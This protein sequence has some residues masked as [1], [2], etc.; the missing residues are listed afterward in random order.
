MKKVMVFV[1]ILMFIALFSQAAGSE[2]KENS[3]YNILESLRDTIE[4]L[5]EN[6]QAEKTSSPVDPSAPLTFPETTINPWS[7][8]TTI[9]PLY[10]TLEL[11]IKGEDVLAARMRLFELG[12]YSK[13]PTQMDFT[14]NMKDYVIEFQKA[15]ALK[16][17]GILTSEVQELLFSDN[18]KPKP[19]PVQKLQKPGNVKASVSDTTVTLTWS[20]VKGAESYNVYR[21]TSAKGTYDKIANIKG[22]L[23]SEKVFQRG[24]SFYYKVEAVTEN[25]QSNQSSSVKAAIPTPSPSPIPEPKYQLEDTG[26]GD[27]GT[28]YGIKWFK[29]N[30]KNTS[31]KYTVDG[32]TIGYYATD[33]YGDKIKAHGFGDYMQYEIITK[34]IKPGN[35]GQTPKIMAY[36]FDDAKRIYVAVIKIH[37]TDGRTIEIPE[38]DRHYWYYEY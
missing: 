9:A 8:P 18:A 33:V 10:R 31:K 28:S 38:N 7:S 13:K 21:S 32:F 26:Y 34:T 1:A 29:N 37:L 19:T 36:G 5:R 4:Q 23:Y 27:S 2:S 3:S 20:S 6:R 30:Y 14:S 25:N 16:A 24:K 12:Y 15:N 17:D 22:T 11:G 35:K